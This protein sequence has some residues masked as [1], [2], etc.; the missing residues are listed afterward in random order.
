MKLHSTDPIKPQEGEPHPDNEHTW[1]AWF[2][3]KSF[4]ADDEFTEGMRVWTHQIWKE[5]KAR[6]AGPPAPS[7][8]TPKSGG[9]FGHWADTSRPVF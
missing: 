7:D 9:H 2:V 1:K 6:W 5:T 4:K 3:K 8:D